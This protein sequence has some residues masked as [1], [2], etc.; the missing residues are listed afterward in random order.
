[1][2]AR[3]RSLAAG[4]FALTAGIGTAC[5]GGGPVSEPAKAPKAN[6]DRGPAFDSPARWLAF[7][8]Q[9][10]NPTA[11]L[12]L[13]DG[14]CLVTTDDGQRWQV[15]PENPTVAPCAGP[16]RAS[17]SPTLDALV[18]AQ[19]VGE[20]YRF[21]SDQG[22]VY[23][24]R[25]PLGAFTKVAR[26]PSPLR[27]VAASGDVIVGFDESGG[28]FYYDGGWNAATLP[29]G[30]R[31]IDIG[32]D[33]S[34][35]ALIVAAPETVLLS[36]DR[37]HSFAAPLGNAPPKVG[38]YE[39]TRAE[40]GQLAVRGVAKNLRWQG[41]RLVADGT[42]LPLV[43]AAQAAIIPAE[44]PRATLL[45]EERAVIDQ[46]AYFE[47]SETLE[48]TRHGL[49]RTA[50][51]GASD[52]I[53]LE[54][55]EACESVRVAASAGV[56]A[57]A[58]TR[59]AE[60]ESNLL[61]DLF[62]SR[63]RGEKLTAAGS[64]V[65]PS[66]ADVTLTVAPDGTMM[67]F[68]ACK[69]DAQPAGEGGA[70]A[71]KA[72]PCTPKAPL[73][74]HAGAVSG[75]SVPNLEE[76]SGHAPLLSLDGRIGYFLGRNRKDSQP[77]VFVTRD[78]GKS[79]K[80]RVLEPPQATSWDDASSDGEEPS[81]S[82]FYLPD[83]ATLTIDETGTIGLPCE[84][85]M[86]FCW[87]TLDAD[88]RVANVATPPEPASMIGGVGA[89][90]LALG[91]SP[92]D[93]ATH[94]WESLDG[95]G[96]WNEVAATAA[97]V[98]YGT[99]GGSVLAC[100]LGGCLFGDELARIGWEG[101]SETAVPAPE[102]QIGVAPEVTL[103]TPI[104][105][106]LRPKT[107]WTRVTGR[108]EERS[109]GSGSNA[110]PSFPR[111]RDLV[112]GKTAFSVAAIDDESGAVEITSVA[113]V[114][115]DAP[116]ATPTKKPLLGARQGKG[117]FATT[118]RS[119]AE[120]YV[121]LRAKVPTTKVGAVD[122]TKPLEG[123]ELAWNNQYLGV[124][125]KKTVKIPGSWSAPLGSGTSLRPALLT[126]AM[127]GVV[128]QATSNDAA[129]YVD[130]G[131]AQSFGFP[132]FSALI[133]DR[134]ATT[135]VDATYVGGTPFGISFVDRSPNAQLFAIARGLPVSD[136]KGAKP[137]PGERARP[138]E[139]FATTLGPALSETDFLY[140]GSRVGVSS[141]WL[142]VTD[143]SASPSRAMAFM[144]ADDGTLEPAV[145]LPTMAD[146]PRETKACTA[147]QRKSELRSVA[148]HFGRYGL[149]MAPQNRHPV[150]I[151]DAPG[152]S[153][154]GS[155]TLSTASDPQWLL[156]DGAVVFGKKGDACVGAYRASGV[157]SG[158]VAV[159]G[160][161]LEH[162]WA[163]RTQIAP[164]DRITKRGVSTAAPTVSAL[165]MRPM[166]CRFQPDLPVPYEVTSRATQ[167]MA[168]D[169]P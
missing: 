57:F 29:A 1:M 157:R 32:V 110:L 74:V 124:L 141:T 81:V 82:P 72:E 63:D 169:T 4:L 111:L 96:S 22:T 140:A 53:P 25:E 67:V 168:D 55:L 164:R 163:I 106:Q 153:T 34:G 121:A 129:I 2:S 80:M 91:D 122:T 36:T 86:G 109:G 137:K 12:I 41:D 126:V 71:A 50:F 37:G 18:G 66:F 92:T 154:Q 133:A 73:F 78:F 17:G 19:R 128:L 39:V 87:A 62:L 85:N 108:P 16:A 162:A 158:L 112:R 150:M 139:L 14:S 28:V 95:G 142:P 160:G 76:S 161:D 113:M 135:N 98:K 47:L 31:P 15:R 117:P 120:G 145:E 7:P 70:S 88:G 59:S 138:T 61:V 100:A 52:K 136:G 8:Q 143:T 148:S 99:R 102:E 45:A 20:L 123:L 69:P 79:Y 107:E 134:R 11:T 119:Q 30:A 64:L 147:E 97:V 118:V 104:S 151:L 3:T 159:I 68:G 149:L 125:A 26:A 58:C 84:E 167:R 75:G 27:H 21:V 40:G 83:G 165:E 60:G 155:L 48:G 144:I 9:T 131:S 10:G 13:N 35:R 5:S 38:A 6:V 166:T 44:G 23:E 156:G 49:V 54:E 77:A 65:T 114:E 46:R 24:S 103:A 94:V 90:V 89:R 101:Q 116:P 130:G 51:D 33:D 93:G 115:R 42:P 127:Q 132:A 146:L 56:L 43:P 105:C 152:P